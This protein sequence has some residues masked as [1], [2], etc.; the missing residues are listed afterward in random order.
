MLLQQRHRVHAVTCREHTHAVAFEQPLR[1]AAHGDRVVDDHRECAPV[2]LVLRRDGRLRP[3]APLGAHERTDVQ[4]D[5]DAAIAEDR[6]ARD[7]AD[8]RHLRSDGLHHDFAAADELIGDQTGRVLTGA[9]QHDGDRDILLG[10]RRGLEADETGQILEAV[11]LTAVVERRRLA[12]QMRGDLGLRQP[13]HALD[14]GQRQ[15]VI[16]LTGPHD[17]RVADG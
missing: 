15:S 13:Q 1:H 3:R 9:H 8:G 14:R 10:Q 5:D 4:D 11:L 12:T 17:Q 16:L 6:R 2:A 7:A